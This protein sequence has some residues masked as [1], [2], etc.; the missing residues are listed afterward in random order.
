MM[1]I[2]GIHKNHPANNGWTCIAHRAT[3]RLYAVHGLKFF[4]CVVC[5]NDL[6]V[7]RRYRPQPT[8]PGPCEQHTWNSC[9][10]GR[11]RRTA[12][13]PAF[14]RWRSYR[15]DRAPARQF[16]RGYSTTRLRIGSIEIVVR[17]V[18]VFAVYSR[19]PHDSAACAAFSHALL[20]DDLSFLIRIQCGNDARLVCGD[21]DLVS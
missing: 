15:P 7:H 20:P 8:V 12:R 5:P 19:A 6:T 3:I 18:D 17:R 9:Y 10:R 21:D 1:G 16:E 13:I 2:A 11:V 14:A 4:R